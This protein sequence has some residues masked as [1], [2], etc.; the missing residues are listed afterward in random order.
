[1]LVEMNPLTFAYNSTSPA[2]NTGGTNI[3]FYDATDSTAWTTLTTSYQTIYDRMRGGGYSYSTSSIVVRAKLT[4]SPGTD[5][6]IDFT[7][8]LSDNAPTPM[9][10]PKHGVVSYQVDTI[11]SASAVIYPGTVSISVVGINNGFIAT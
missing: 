7:I 6:K 10:Q 1:M 5:G 11:T 2:S 3:G 9:K 8:I 4:N